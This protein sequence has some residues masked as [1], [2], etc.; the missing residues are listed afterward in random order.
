MGI[1][2]EFLSLFFG[3][4]EKAPDQR[5]IPLCPQCRCELA[6][7]EGGKGCYRCKDCL[8]LWVSDA[9]LAA[10][11][12]AD[13]TQIEAILEG[14]TGSHTYT[15][16]HESRRCPGCDHPMDNYPFGYQS[17]IWVDGCPV[18]H[19]V[20]LDSGE[21]RMIRDYQR[22]QKGP[23][24]AADRAKM[25]NAFLDGAN[26]ARR[27]MRVELPERDNDYSYLSDWQGGD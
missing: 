20:W 13:D 23:L 7:V 24:S 10:A 18:G 5:P 16:S 12:A 17:G 1:F 22:R 4:V 26:T 3:R 9:F 27:N 14:S 2:G 15:R 19:G 25:M 11:L 21:L 8:G 6:K